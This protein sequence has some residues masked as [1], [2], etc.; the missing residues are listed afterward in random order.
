MFTLNGPGRGYEVP[1]YEEVEQVLRWPT[2]SSK[3]TKSLCKDGIHHFLIP[4]FFKTITELQNRG[5]A[6]SSGH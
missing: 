5:R 3:P 2:G 1:V 4:G 6:F